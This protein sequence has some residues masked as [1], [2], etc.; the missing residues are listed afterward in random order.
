MMERASAKVV[1]TMAHLTKAVAAAQL[2]PSSSSSSA[3]SKGISLKDQ[4]VVAVDG[5]WDEIIKNSKP[6]CP[7]TGVKPSNLAYVLFTSGSTGLPKGVMIEHKALANMVTIYVEKY[8]S[9]DDRVSQ[10]RNYIC[11]VPHTYPHLIIPHICYPTYLFISPICIY[12]IYSL[13]QKILESWGRV[14]KY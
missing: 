9:P 13:A 7:Q 1:L 14:R 8:L 2:T 12:H 3:P 4:R 5:H 10:V 6:D 11:F